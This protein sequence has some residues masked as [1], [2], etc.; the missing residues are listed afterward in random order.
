MKNEFIIFQDY[1]EPWKSDSECCLHEHIPSLFNNLEAIYEFNKSFL[2]Q[3][4]DAK[5]DPS[6]TAKVFINNTGFSIYTDYCT[7][8]PITISVLTELM[9]N[10]DTAKYFKQVQMEKQHDLPLGSYLLKPVQ[11]ILRYRMLLQ[12]KR[13]VKICFIKIIIIC[14]YRGY[15]KEVNLNINT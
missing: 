5:L 10:E 2:E 3:L 11:R 1:L 7:N 15:L 4:R 6:A 13:N 14:Y 12:V 8:Y 9:K